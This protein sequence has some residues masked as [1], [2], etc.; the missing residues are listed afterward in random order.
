[1]SLKRPFTFPLPSHALDCFVHPDPANALHSPYRHTPENGPIETLAG[2]GH[3]ILRTT[4]GH[5]TPED[6]AEAPQDILQRMAKLPWSHIPRCQDKGDWKPLDD[7]RGKIYATDPITPFT[8]SPPGKWRFSATPGIRIG[9]APIVP[10]S[11]LQQVARLPRVEVL[12]RALSVKDPILFRFTGGIG[13]I[14]HHRS[15]LNTRPTASLFEPRH[16]RI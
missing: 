9:G 13:C 12:V 4:R 5:F 15:F 6:F 1:M 8:E 2:N 10:R 3:V 16:H 14:G 7:V 11:L